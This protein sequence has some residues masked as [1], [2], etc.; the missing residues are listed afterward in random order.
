MGI[1]SG[2]ICGESSSIVF[3]L[4][5][6]K[7]LRSRENRIKLCF[8]VLPNNLIETYNSMKALPINTYQKCSDTFFSFMDGFNCIKLF[9]ASVS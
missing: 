4:N 7:V 8:D 3:W 5:A 9:Y 6:F 1:S 2:S